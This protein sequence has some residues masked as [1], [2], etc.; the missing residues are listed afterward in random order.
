MSVNKDFDIIMNEIS[1]GLT[2][3]PQTDMKNLDA[4]S[5][6]NTNAYFAAHNLD[7][8]KAFEDFFINKLGL[9]VTKKDVEVK[10]EHKP[11][12]EVDAGYER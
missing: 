12:K 7:S 8:G 10:K 3:D 1:S 6:E 5:L 9:N 11:K 2:G 4:V